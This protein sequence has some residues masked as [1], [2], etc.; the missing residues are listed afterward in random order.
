MTHLKLF[1]QRVAGTFRHRVIPSAKRGGKSFGSKS[2]HFIKTAHEGRKQ[3]SRE[4]GEFQERRKERD[5]E[6]HNERV[7]KLERQIK[8]ANLREQLRIMNKGKRRFS[9]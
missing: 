5:I 4:F 6:K 7:A 8:E 9:F 3:F 2:K 1:G